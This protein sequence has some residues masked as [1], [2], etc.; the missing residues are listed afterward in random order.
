MSSKHLFQQVNE[1]IGMGLDIDFSKLGLNRAK[2]IMNMQIVSAQEELGLT[3]LTGTQV[4]EGNFTTDVGQKIL[5]GFEV[6]FKLINPGG[7]QLVDATQGII[8]FTQ[9]PLGQGQIWLIQEQLGAYKVYDDLLSPPND[10]KENLN[11]P[12]NGEIDLFFV[13]E[14]G[15]WYALWVDGVNPPRYIQLELRELLQPN[16]DNSIAPYSTMYIP[17]EGD[18][19]YLQ[20]LYPVDQI[21]VSAVNSS[22]GHLGCGT[23]QFAYRYFNTITKRYSKFSLIGNPVPVIASDT[24][25]TSTNDIQGL[26]AGSKTSKSITLT[27]NKSHRHNKYYDSI[28]LAVVKN[29]TGVIQELVVSLLP[30]SRE[31]YGT[32]DTL[33]TIVYTGGEAEEV[34]QV[35]DIVTDEAQLLTAKT[36]EEHEGRI[37]LMN[38]RYSDLRDV[39]GSNTLSAQT[40]TQELPVNVDPMDAEIASGKGFYDEMNNHRYR[41]YFRGEVYR[42][43]RVYVNKFGQWNRPRA[44]E[45]NDSTTMRYN[46]ANHAGTWQLNWAEP[47]VGDWKFADRES[48]EGSLFSQEQDAIRPFGLRLDG[49][50]NHP[51]WAYGMAIVRMDRK[52]NI[53]GQT[54]V[55]NGVAYQ[56]GAFQSQYYSV[57]NQPTYTRYFYIHPSSFD[58]DG[59]ED[60]FGPKIMAMGHS[61]NLTH[62]LAQAGADYRSNHH[63]LIWERLG[64]KR[65]G[66]IDPVY[67]RSTYDGKSYDKRMNATLFLYPMEYLAN[68]GTGGEEASEIF[69][70]GTERLKVIDCVILKSFNGY[71]DSRFAVGVTPAQANFMD[72][73]L[74]QYAWVFAPANKNAYY[75]HNGHTVGGML[76]PGLIPSGGHPVI[77]V[78]HDGPI[79]IAWG[80][81]FDWNHSEY[82]HFTP[83]SR[84]EVMRHIRYIQNGA[85]LVEQQTLNPD[86]LWRDVNMCPPAPISGQRGLVISVPYDKG[87]DSNTIEMVYDPNYFL[88]QNYVAGTPTIPFSDLFP[89]NPAIAPSAIAES[90]RANDWTIAEWDLSKAD[91]HKNPVIEPGS[92]VAVYIA[93]IERGL[94]DDRYG[95]SS[96]MA[97]P[98]IFTGAYTPIS[99]AQIDANTQIGID[100]FGGDCFIT[101]SRIYLRDN[102]IRKD[103]APIE[104]DN[105]GSPEHWHIIDPGTPSYYY[106]KDAVK[107]TTWTSFVEILDLWVEST[108]NGHYITRSQDQYPSGIKERNADNEDVAGITTYQ[109]PPGAGLAAYLDAARYFYH[110]GYSA[111]NLHKVWASRDIAETTNLHAETRVMYGV[112]GILNN[113]IDFDRFLTNDYID[114]DGSAGHGTKLVKL[115]NNRMMA[116]QRNGIAILSLGQVPTTDADGLTIQVK[117]GAVIGSVDYISNNTDVR[118]GAGAFRVRCVR[119]GTSGVVYILDTER[120]K[121][122]AV[123]GGSVKD[124]FEDQIA[125][126]A[127]MMLEHLNG[128][129]SPPDEADYIRFSLWIDNRHGRIRFYCNGKTAFQTT[130]LYGASFVEKMQLWESLLSFDVNIEIIGAFTTGPRT[131]WLFNDNGIPKI[132]NENWVMGE[133]TGISSLN[134]TFLGRPNVGWVELRLNNGQHAHVPKVLVNVIANSDI[135]PSGASADWGTLSEFPVLFGPAAVP[136]A[137]VPFRKRRHNMYIANEFPLYN[138]ARPKDANI[139]IFVTFDA[140]AAK[141]LHRV[142]S[143][144]TTYR[145]RPR[146]I[147]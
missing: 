142:R 99:K 2:R 20:R 110:P 134:Q 106:I 44:L 95:V 107:A 144:I 1:V 96:G 55:I 43:G 47:G 91:F 28:Q 39:G 119:R 92:G 77:N 7:S 49:L 30:P 23:Y 84:D 90:Y 69:F 31:Y 14:D 117:S 113:G 121:M 132:H 126:H 59:S 70:D 140:N 48:E 17:N 135:Q 54:P 130:Q 38:I 141:A 19:L 15:S 85:R 9:N 122:W 71:R 102:A 34:T 3:N 118:G 108:V 147:L 18:L 32:T 68:W 58:Y 40:I 80:R 89:G 41:G 82:R 145:I 22:G 57:F 93:N 24:A 138:N 10:R 76:T 64:T 35:L 51:A 4:A 124:I 109:Y 65:Y 21:E 52:K 123:N 46:P 83:L 81:K 16:R 143:I 53:L 60:F 115:E 131:Y 11:L 36:I 112:Q 6:N 61:K 62:G 72:G 63:Y 42:F 127:S 97:Q 25:T 111:Q 98:Y 37:Y 12:T 78:A 79:E 56:G 125:S 136:T 8:F 50:R 26:L 133:A 45:L 13:L 5:A 103:S 29:T 100:V 129:G 120:K 75:Y 67:D 73:T 105:P 114:L 139:R 94:G 101:R 88:Y 128:P 146:E 74:S 87:E 66:A 137:S 33:S 116:V 27:L 104:E 86:E